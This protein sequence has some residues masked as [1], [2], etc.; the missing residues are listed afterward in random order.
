[1]Q[2]P[3]ADL[4]DLSHTC[5]SVSMLVMDAS[6]FEKYF[7]KIYAAVNRFRAQPHNQQQAAQLVGIACQLLEAA[8]DHHRS[9]SAYATPSAVTVYDETVGLLVHIMSTDL[10]MNDAVYQE[11]RKTRLVLSALKACRINPPGHYANHYSSRYGD[12]DANEAGRT[13]AWRYAQDNIEEFT[14][15]VYNLAYYHKY[16]PD[17]FLG[18][19]D[20]AALSLFERVRSLGPG[21]SMIECQ[22]PPRDA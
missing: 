9:A 10:R 21:A 2:D 17:P 13:E 12:A 11:A 16:V 4:K 22:A 7:G 8:V 3:I 19:P 6:G 14:R 20:S 18:G 1:M 5:D 15:F